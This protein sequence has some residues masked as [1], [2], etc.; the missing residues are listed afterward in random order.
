MWHMTQTL[1]SI[2]CCY[3]WRQEKSVK[4]QSFCIGF[5]FYTQF[6]YIRQ[7]NG[8]ILADIVFHFCVC[9]C[10]CVSVCLFVCLSVCVHVAAAFHTQYIQ[11]YGLQI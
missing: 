1:N 5:R 7:V 9:V 2:F 3:E 11:S 4:Y 10:V 8:V 6:N